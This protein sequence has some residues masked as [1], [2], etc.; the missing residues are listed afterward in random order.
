M[1]DRRCMVCG[2]SLVGRHHLTKTCSEQCRDVHRAAAARQRALRYRAENIE[3][4]RAKDRS[5]AKTEQRKA[6]HRASYRRRHP[7]ERKTCC[8]CGSEFAANKNAVTCSKVCREVRYG[9]NRKRWAADNAERVRERKTENRRI[10]RAKNRERIREKD[11]EFSRRKYIIHN[12]ALE[13]LRASVGA[14][15]ADDLLRQFEKIEGIQK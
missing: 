11:R 15:R 2:N 8:V 6:V 14:E 7:I 4:V 13:F 10:W 5:R 12:A 9:E 1:P 3:I